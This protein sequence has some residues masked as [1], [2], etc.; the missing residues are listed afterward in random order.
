TRRSAHASRMAHT[1][2]ARRSRLQGGTGSKERAP[3]SIRGV[4]PGD[5]AAVG[6]AAVLERN[7]GEPLSKR[8]PSARER[9]PLV[10][11]AAHEPDELVEVTATACELERYGFRDHER[12]AARDGV[13]EPGED[14]ALV[15]LDVDLDAVDRQRRLEQH[16]TGDHA[17]G[18]SRRQVVLSG[19]EVSEGARARVS[20]DDAELEHPRA[21]PE[22]E[23]VDAGPGDAVVGERAPDARRAERVRLDGVH[24]SRG[25]D[26]TRRE[27]GDHADV[28]ADVDEPIPGFQ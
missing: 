6:N 26:E 25:A 8:A 2:E 11:V 12:A 28:R 23:G 1:G 24:G 14:M 22:P 15:P 9:E 10:A 7:E 17:D 5:V 16:V 27:Q 3:P 20:V 18:H 13:S 21:I 4:D 19:I